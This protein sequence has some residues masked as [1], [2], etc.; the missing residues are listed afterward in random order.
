MAKYLLII[1]IDDELLEDYENFYVDC[2][3]RAERKNEMVNESI[4]Y[5]EDCPLKP[6]P[7]VNDLKIDILSHDRFVDGWNKCLGEIIGEE[8]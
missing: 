4:K 2:D 1:D 5:I 6:M 3:L 7:K 8:E